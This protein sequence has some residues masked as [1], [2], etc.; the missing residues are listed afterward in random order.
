VYN[1]EC[2]GRQTLFTDNREEVQQIIADQTA[3]VRSYH[4]K[5]IPLKNIYHGITDLNPVDTGVFADKDLEPYVTLDTSL[6]NP[7]EF[8][9]HFDRI[10]GEDVLRNEDGSLDKL[11]TQGVDIRAYSSSIAAIVIDLNYIFNEYP[12]FAYKFMAIKKDIVYEKDLTLKEIF[13]DVTALVYDHHYRDLIK[14]IDE[15]T[16]KQELNKANKSKSVPDLQVTDDANKL[17]I[18]TSFAYRTIIPLMCDYL[19]TTDL[20]NKQKEIAFYN[21][22]NKIIVDY[23]KADDIDIKN[24]LYK[25]VQPRV[26]KTIYPNQV[27]WKY[28]E[29]KSIDEKT[30]VYDI[31]QSLIRQIINKMTV[32][33]SSISFLHAVIKNKIR[34]T[35]HV[36]YRFNYKPLRLSHVDSDDDIDEADKMSLLLQHKF[37][38]ID[39][40]SNNLTIRDFIREGINEYGIQPE[41][42]NEV[43]KGLKTINEFQRAMMNIY[44]MNQFQIKNYTNNDAVILLI[45]MQKQLAETNK[46]TILDKLLLAKRTDVNNKRMNIN[47]PS[48]SLIESLTYSELMNDFTWVSN[49]LA[50]KNPIINF[51]SIAAY[52]FVKYDGSEIDDTNFTKDLLIEEISTLVDSIA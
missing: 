25:I 19:G 50:I 20:T 27:I 2:G 23:S 32:N 1:V 16:Y 45:I 31:Q 13:A 26:K 30:L 47:R 15:S 49:L 18:E 6:K 11:Y 43:R 17:I 7:K 14:S 46:Y 29:N 39:D 3:D 28:L 35:F 51:G 37:N 5:V 48:K 21:V 42:I 24:K 22:F 8:I 10:T 12:E 34:F 33:K 36:K 40:V 52:N 9:I 41:L 38:D 4:P 44:Y